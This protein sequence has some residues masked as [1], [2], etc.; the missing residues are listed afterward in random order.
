MLKFLLQLLEVQLL[1]VQD[2]LLPDLLFFFF[3]FA[4]LMLKII[5]GAQIQTSIC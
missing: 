2:V 4:S 5:I 1:M 3:F